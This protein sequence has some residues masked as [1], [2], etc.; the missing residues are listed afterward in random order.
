MRPRGYG[1]RRILWLPLSQM[2]V[3]G[4]S[5]IFFYTLPVFVGF[6]ARRRSRTQRR[7]VSHLPDTD[8]VLRWPCLATGA[9]T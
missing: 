5:S 9:G 8:R 2:P 6:L 4:R 3:N 1:I 7:N